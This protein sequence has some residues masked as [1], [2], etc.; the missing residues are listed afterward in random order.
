MTSVPTYFSEIK[1][2]HNLSELGGIV[3]SM[4]ARPE[5]Y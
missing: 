2:L 4:H 5:M 1:T 3:H